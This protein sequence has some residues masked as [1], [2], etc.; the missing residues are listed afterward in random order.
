[1]TTELTEREIVLVLCLGTI[2]NPQTS[3][4]F[5]KRKQIFDA[6][7]K[8]RLPGKFYKD[9]VLTELVQAVNAEYMGLSKK[10][11]DFVDKSGIKF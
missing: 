9:D 3:L 8:V 4:S 2:I 1:M 5:E 10:I 6:M 11:L 7:V